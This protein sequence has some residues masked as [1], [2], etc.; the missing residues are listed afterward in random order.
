M[1][2]YK[3][4]I[5]TEELIPYDGKASPQDIY[6]FQRKMG[7]LGYVI[8]MT[9][10]DVSRAIGKLS[11]FLKNPSPTHQT[12]ADLAISYLY[13]IRI[14]AIEFSASKDEQQVF[15]LRQ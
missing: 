13:G 14:L 8:V 15:R 2:P 11:E 5:P 10:P 3:T 1:K 6:R 12:A 9:R 4:P 7:S